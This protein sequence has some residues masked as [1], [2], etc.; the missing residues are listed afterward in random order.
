[1]RWFTSDK[2]TNFSKHQLELY[3]D[4]TKSTNQQ[5]WD[6]KE[7]ANDAVYIQRKWQS[8]K[9]LVLAKE[10]KLSAHR[11]REDAEYLLC[12]VREKLSSAQMQLACAEAREKRACLAFKE[13]AEAHACGERIK[14]ALLHWIASLVTLR[15]P[16][17]FVKSVTRKLLFYEPYW[18]S[19]DSPAMRCAPMQRRGWNVLH[20]Q[21][22]KVRS[23]R[24]KFLTRL[25]NDIYHIVTITEDPLHLPKS[26]AP[27]RIPGSLDTFTWKEPAQQ[28][29]KPGLR[30]VIPY[31]IKDIKLDLREL[32][33]FPPFMGIIVVEGLE[34]ENGKKTSWR[35]DPVEIRELLLTPH[36]D[37]PGV[38]KPELFQLPQWAGPTQQDHRESF[39]AFRRS[40]SYRACSHRNI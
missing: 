3:K 12:T 1:M 22:V 4:L 18:R 36:K 17:H 6:P 13:V 19:L 14:T 40:C 30:N 33:Q 26:R 29:R 24:F 35:I 37:L 39:N 8:R 38:E 27:P 28:L 2:A 25:P 31:G 16:N 34:P 32:A 21:G 23:P 7:N 5:A 9:A 10:L 11:Q 15:L 20:R